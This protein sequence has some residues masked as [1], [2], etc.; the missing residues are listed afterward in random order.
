MIVTTRRVLG[1]VALSYVAAGIVTLVFMGVANIGASWS[2]PDTLVGW[3][4][5]MGLLAV[6]SPAVLLVLA[7]VD[8]VLTASKGQRRDGFVFALLPGTLASLL[9]VPYPEMIPLVAWLLA[10]GL[11]FGWFMRL[12]KLRTAV[13][14]RRPGWIRR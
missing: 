13:P 10:V 5:E 3:I 8:L 6:G 14:E 11:L 12:P 1:N 4:Y 7:I 2:I 9:I